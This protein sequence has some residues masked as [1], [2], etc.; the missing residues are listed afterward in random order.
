MLDEEAEEAEAATDLGRRLDA[1]KGIALIAA[2]TGWPT[3]LRII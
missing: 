1:S 3:L 2:P